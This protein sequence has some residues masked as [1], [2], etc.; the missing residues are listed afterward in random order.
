MTSPTF[1]LSLECPIFSTNFNKNLDFF[2][3]QSFTVVPLPNSTR[4]RS[5]G[6]PLITRGQTN[7]LGH[8]EANGLFRD[9]ARLKNANYLSVQITVPNNL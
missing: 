2:L 7:E 9:Y 3:R 8:D 1:G 4:I 5:V 6:T